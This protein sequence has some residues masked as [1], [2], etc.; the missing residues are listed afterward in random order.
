MDGIDLEWIWRLAES[1]FRL[2][3]A[4]FFP[5]DPDHPV[6]EKRVHCKKTAIREGPNKATYAREAV[7]AGADTNRYGNEFRRRM[8][9]IDT[10]GVGFKD[11]ASTAIRAAS[12]FASPFLNALPFP[13]SLPLT[14]RD[15]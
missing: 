12:S 10:L 1:D 7:P 8:V 6:I 4:D 2:D 14:V 13:S 5:P 9:S 11:N 3:F 15:E